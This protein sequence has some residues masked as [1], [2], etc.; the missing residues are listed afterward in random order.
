MILRF[1]GQQHRLPGSSSFSVGTPKS[2]SEPPGEV[3][4][5]PKGS[6]LTRITS[7]LLE[8]EA[9]YIVQLGLPGFHPDKLEIRVLGHQTTIKGS[10]E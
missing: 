6:P 8:T 9:A 1:V 7:N 2:N 10:Y 5:E 4:G 3:K